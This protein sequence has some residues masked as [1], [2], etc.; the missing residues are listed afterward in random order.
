MD[1][2]D[3]PHQTTGTQ[4]VLQK[5]R[6]HERTEEAYRTIEPRAVSRV[7]DA[8]LKGPCI[9]TVFKSLSRGARQDALGF[10]TVPGPRGLLVFADRTG[11]REA[12]VVSGEAFDSSLAAIRIDTRGPLWEH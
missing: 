11:L 2:L 4:H 10:H 3:V 1:L 7:S 5:T 9:S 12:V 6:T 8:R